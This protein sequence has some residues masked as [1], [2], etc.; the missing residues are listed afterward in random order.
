[1]GEVRWEKGEGRWGMEEIGSEMGDGRWEMGEAG[2]EH[3]IHS[4]PC[5]SCI[6]LLPSHFQ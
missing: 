4:F 2:E 3:V 5:F 6:S 1:M